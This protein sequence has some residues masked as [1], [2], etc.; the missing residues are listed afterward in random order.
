MGRK[1]RWELGAG[2]REGPCPQEVPGEGQGSTHGAGSVLGQG[3]RTEVAGGWKSGV[4]P[5]QKPR[6]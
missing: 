6:L 3:D 4:G 2:G 1:P 5:T